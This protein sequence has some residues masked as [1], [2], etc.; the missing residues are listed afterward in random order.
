MKNILALFFL[1]FSTFSFTQESLEPLKTNYKLINGFNNIRSSNIT[2]NGFIYLTDTISLPVI[3][4]F[5]TNKFK[6]YLTDT[7]LSNISD[8]NWYKI[9]DLDG[10][11][12]PLTANYMSSPTFEYIYDSVNLNGL[13]TL[14]VLVNELTPDTFLLYNFS[15]YPITYDTVILWPNVTII[16]SLWTLATPDISYSDPSPDLTQDS[17]NLFFVQPVNEDF[18]KIWLDKDVYLNNNYSSN[19]WTL[20]I[21]TFDGLNASGLPYDWTTGVTDWTDVLTSKPLFLSQ[22]TISDS[23]YF[24]FFFQSGGNGD[25]PESD[26]SLKL[27]FYIPSNNQWSPIWST[28]GFESDDW[29]YQHILLDSN[30]YF[31]DGFQ[32]RFSSYGSLNG[33]LDHWNLDYVYFNE[34][35][36]QNDTLMQDWA[37]TSIPISV[38]DNYSS[39][40]WKHYKLATSDIILNSL[41]IPTYN[42]SD[43]AKLLQPCAMDLFYNDLLL[44]NHPYSATV[45][46]IPPL[47]YFDMN[48]DYGNNLTLNTALSDTFVDFDFRYYLS[49]NT[50][51]ERLS[52]NDTI[53]HKQSFQNY[54]SYD[55]GSAE[56]AYGLV[57]NGAELAYRYQLLSGV[58]EDTLKSIKIHF[59]PSVYDASN[60]PFFLQIWADSL[61]F[62]GSLIYSS[63]N[64]D[65]PELY[66]PQYNSGVNGF[67]D[68]DLPILVAVT[69]TFY[70]GWKQSS[71]ARLNVGFDKNVDTQSEIFFNLGSGFQNT[72]FN[73]SLMIRPVFISD[74]DEVVNVETTKNLN[75]D[76]QLYPNPANSFF[77]FSEH[78]VREVNIYDLNGRLFFKNEPIK[79]QNISVSNW[80]NG[81]YIITFL[82]DNGNLVRKK[83]LIQH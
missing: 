75:N 64:F 55:D 17:L 33:S 54:Y 36:S 29:F 47:S 72:I 3:D 10:N 40:P 83:L 18:N 66:Y 61:G 51:P 80:N 19:P 5:S 74:M 68:Y 15:F 35:R 48:Y 78:G 26:D 58:E 62:P 76:I 43:N 28:N 34:N 11:R 39:V 45:L 50:T 44:S 73:G 71:S 31:Q 7:S 22:K 46:N 27:E 79:D 42:S 70:I 21:V 12:V 57:G 56:A 25:T 77:S 38:I 65:F 67:F 60:D 14:T 32:F 52:E 82:M 8:S 4:D 69:D 6:N 24:S 2:N 23:I 1:S 16:D 13:D 20:G 37:F 9:Y 53:Y 81:I 49:T 30:L 59:S 63:D 41:I